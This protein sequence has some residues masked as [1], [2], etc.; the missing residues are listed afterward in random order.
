MVSRGGPRKS[1]RQLSYDD[2]DMEPST[3]SLCAGHHRQFSIPATW[4]NEEARSLAQSLK[5][6][7]NDQVCYP[8]RKDMT[9]MLAD[10]GHVP[11]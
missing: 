3:C 2:E 11:R 8:C 1:R 4:R 6:S 7:L 9:R 10:K 5:V